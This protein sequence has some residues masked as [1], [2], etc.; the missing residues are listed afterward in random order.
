MTHRGLVWRNRAGLALLLASLAQMIGDLAGWRPLV[1]LAAAWGVSP[2]PRVFSD[3]GGLETF[4][5]R[6]TLVW[7]GEDGA[8]ESLEISP[9]IY[10]RLAGPYNR[11]NVY[12]AALSYAPRLPE[13]LWQPVYC[14]GLAP[15]GP[16]RR[17]LGLPARTDGLAVEIVTK[18]R[19]R[20]DRWRLEPP[21]R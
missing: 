7:R 13:E 8:A 17:E 5:S 11:R 1:G 16:L 3:A 6:F 20:D 12:G 10:G 14:Y 19:G 18:T 15:D 2:R 4:A 9:A 21:C